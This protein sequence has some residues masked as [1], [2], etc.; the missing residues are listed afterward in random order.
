MPTVQCTRSFT[1]PSGSLQPSQLLHILHTRRPALRRDIRSTLFIIPIL[2]FFIACI[3]PGCDKSASNSTHPSPTQQ[4]THH[5]ASPARPPT[6]QQ[7]PST[8]DSPPSSTS[9]TSTPDPLPTPKPTLRSSIDFKPSVHG[10]AFINSFTG[11][12]LPP[13]IRSAKS[14]F[15][16]V[17]NDST[18]ATMGSNFGLCGGMSASAADFYYANIAVPTIS[19]EP[20]E[21]SPLRDYI[22][23]RQV[24]SLGTAALFAIKYVEWMQLPDLSEPVPSVQSTPNAQSN[25]TDS[26]ARRTATEWL[27]IR[28]RLDAHQLVPLGLIHAAAGR[29]SSGRRNAASDN[30]QVLAYAYTQTPN[31]TPNQTPHQ[32]TIR[33]YDPNAPRDDSATIILDR[34]SLDPLQPEQWRGVLRFT[35]TGR[36]TRERIVRGLF[37][38]PYT[39]RSPEFAITPDTTITQPAPK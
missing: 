17:I 8:P 21:G 34:A 32:I 18:K 27:L 39:P 29:D 13:S 16:K 33:V 14:G 9:P 15:L 4:N 38:M 19:T 26:A 10:F 24:D 1:Q 22:Y 28:E 11:S 3:L 7:P 23:S 12:S 31:Q 35:S 30:H 37:A 6:M 20:V 25:W 5:Q 36:P 2:P